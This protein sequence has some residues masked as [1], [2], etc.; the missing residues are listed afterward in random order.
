MLDKAKISVALK[1]LI[2]GEDLSALPWWKAWL[3]KSVRVCYVAVRD[4]MDGELTLQAMSLVY[5]TL[6]A[7][8]PLL[9]R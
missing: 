6:L 7:L 5:T 4:V 1:K 9:V 2:W 3:I 8:V